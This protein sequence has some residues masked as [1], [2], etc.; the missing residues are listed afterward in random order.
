M[1]TIDDP[2]GFS[3]PYRR[4]PHYRLMT[5]SHS[6]KAIRVASGSL[7]YLLV[8]AGR[9]V[10][11]GRKWIELSTQPASTLTFKQPRRRRGTATTPE[12]T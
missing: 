5:L 4:E 3:P 11:P 1:P 2:P 9:S 12:H 10:H 8:L 7:A 6:G